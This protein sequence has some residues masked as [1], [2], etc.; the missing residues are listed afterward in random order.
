[1][2]GEWDRD[3]CRRRRVASNDQRTG[4]LLPARAGRRTD[5]VGQLLG[6][7]AGCGSG[8]GGRRATA[9][10]GSDA[11]LV[12]PRARSVLLRGRDGGDLDTLPGMDELHEG[13]F[14]ED[15]AAL[16]GKARVQRYVELEHA[17]TDP[18]GGAARQVI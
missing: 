3:R 16:D 12:L 13:L 4:A 5:R 8:C 14:L 6:L 7:P 17:L 11:A 15:L 10:A 1:M 2:S 9:Q 18:E